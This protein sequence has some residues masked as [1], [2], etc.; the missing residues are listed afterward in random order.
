MTV[1]DVRERSSEA[2]HG[3]ASPQGLCSGGL[4]RLESHR[5]IAHLAAVCHHSLLTH[6]SWA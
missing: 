3:G 6:M 1:L 2:G 5:G 4:G